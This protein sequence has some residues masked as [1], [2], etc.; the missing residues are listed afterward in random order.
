MARIA[1]ARNPADTSSIPFAPTS[2]TNSA[3]SAGPVSAPAVP[4]AAMNPY[5]RFA[6]AVS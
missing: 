6:C 3:V 5:S 2:V 4:P 1:S